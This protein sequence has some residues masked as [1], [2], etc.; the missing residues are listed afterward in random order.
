MPAA[1][2]QIFDVDGYPL[3]Y[4][5]AGDGIPLLLIHGSLIDYRAWASQIEAFAAAYRTI[6]VSLRHCYPERWNGRGGDFTVSRHADDLAAFIAGKA[7][8]PVHLVGHSRGGAVA[9]QLALRHPQNVRGLVL[10][11][12]GGFEDLL[13]DTPDGRQMAEESAT[14]F[15]RL[16]DDLAAG[17]VLRAARAF[18]DA[19]GG[20]GTWDRCTPEQKQILLDNIATGPAGAERPH[21]TGR[22]VAPRPLLLVTGALARAGTR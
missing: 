16:R 3:A 20:A 18:V 11:D 12:P 21:W 7:L 2:L 9:V 10:A 8:G 4:Q 5:E 19:L 22:L 1:N 6:A 17:D 13:P 14:M 15:A